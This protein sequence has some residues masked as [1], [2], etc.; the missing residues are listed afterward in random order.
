MKQAVGF[1]ICLLLI[2]AAAQ[3]ATAQRPELIVQT[4]HP[5]AVQAIAFSPDGRTLASGSWDN[6][7]KLWDAASGAQLRTLG[8]HYGRVYSVVFSPDGKTLASGGGGFVLWDVETGKRIRSFDTGT[9]LAFSPDGKTLVIESGEAVDL[10]AFPDGKVLQS[11]NAHS[12]NV[13]SAAFSRD[14][15]ILATASST[16]KLWNLSTGKEIRTLDAQPGIVT[17]VA[18]SPDGKSLASGGYDATVKIWDIKSGTL[19][20]ILKGHSSN[21]SSVAFSP[22]S[23]FVASGGGDSKARLWEVLTGKLLH[24]F[25]NHPSFL[26]V[27]SVAFSP[28]GKTLASGVGGNVIGRSLNMV[29]LWDVTNGTEL[30]VLRGYSE[31]VQGVVFS[32]SARALI[33]KGEVSIHGKYEHGLRIWS[34]SADAEPRTLIAEAF[35]LSSDGKT[36][37]LG[38]E[39]TIEIWNLV[40]NTLSR[41]L[42]ASGRVRAIAIDAKS[43]TLAS[44][45]EGSSIILWDLKTGVQL[46]QL[47]GYASVLAF[48]P[49]GKMI[50][51][52]EDNELR[53]WDVTTGAVRRIFRGYTANAQIVGITP[54]GSTLVSIGTVKGRDGYD[55]DEITLWGLLSGKKLHSLRGA[56]YAVAI[57]NSTRV[58]PDGRLIASATGEGATNISL[59][60]VRT[61]VKIRSF[62][63]DNT[64]HA[65]NFSPDGK[66]LA[67]GGSNG[68][69]YLWDIATGKHVSTLVGHENWV[70]SVAF[71]SD[72]KYLVTGSNDTTVKV[73]NVNN[74]TELTSLLSIGEKDWLVTTPTGL[75]DGSPAA[76]RKILWR[77]SPSLFDVLPAEAF[78]N[79]F[80]SPGLLTDIFAGKDTKV[81]SDISQKDRRQPQLKLSAADTRSNARPGPRNI[82]V[83]IEVSEAAADKQHK[84][85]SGAQ[86]VRLFRNGSLVKAWHGDVLGGQNSAA[87]EETVPIVAGE[88]RFTAYAFNHDNIKSSDATLSVTGAES[89]KRQ[90][91]AYV[92][93]VGVNTY[94][95]T[96]YN[97][98]YA[99]PDAQDFAGEIRRQQAAL[100]KY[101]RVE[102]IP[103]Y[104]KD[105]TKANILQKLSELS[106]R[107]Q[108]EDAVIVY[109]SGH[110]TAARQR[111]YLI[112]Y[113]LG[114]QGPRTKLSAA[115][116][117]SILD[118]S[119]SDRELEA[120]F[121]KID[122]G[123]LLMVIDACNS[124]Q[125]LDSE[126]KRRGPMN[127]KGLAQ[128]AY[129]KGMYIMTA[130]QSYQAAWE[131]SRLGHGFLTYALVEEGLKKGTADKEPK[132]DQIVLREWLDYATERVPQMQEEKLK[133]TPQKKDQQGRELEFVF[134]E[135]DETIKDPTKRN[136][137]RPRVFYRRELESS[138]LIIAR[139]QALP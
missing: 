108:P 97:L 118:H 46:R 103:L 18:F 7:V 53:L 129:E 25:A 63:G 83:K 114:Y 47:G 82:A 3:L 11:L 5:D 96:N 65:L 12:E 105:A 13:N 16:I 1:T 35:A 66:Y 64:I 69:I 107:A 67:S 99:V 139:P 100:K 39:N 124:G 22:D 102:V 98:K 33:S 51:S 10:L 80:Y 132:D 101:E 31:A 34:L 115:D 127:S 78:F 92:L 50:L 49:D 4:G 9:P 81:P 133:E 21:V 20:L 52:A 123:Q 68:T 37:A 55:E 2:L 85:G 36:M 43:E 138:P 45:D 88:N 30:N 44:G 122:A 24:T 79:E 137:Q 56:S 87:L 117:N 90:G 23:K 94:S 84:A 70:S 109:F 120:A 130:A 110:G 86:D 28:D 54:N 41:T 125:A 113:D 95:N 76:W 60:D 112:P 48:S 91:A 73:W 75:F 104:D 89:L 131:A 19:G 111:F 116:L 72:G 59:W 119:I 135:G 57:S 15:T 42:N 74:R 77:F 134:V 58:S 126:E 61:G 136:I 17:S 29:E 93:A 38:R 14:G 32:P 62:K 40:T 6:S 8:G 71:S 26:R 121:E 27:T 106:T 128:L